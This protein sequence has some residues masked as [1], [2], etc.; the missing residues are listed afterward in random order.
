MT[1]ATALRV[2][3]ILVV[4]GLCTELVAQLFLVPATF[5]VF[6]A[7]GVPCLTAGTVVYLVHI[8]R[9]LRRKDAS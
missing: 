8:F 6:V 9:T 1:S 2:A 7:V 4:I 5:L 3:V